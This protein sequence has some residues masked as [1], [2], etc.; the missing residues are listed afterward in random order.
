MSSTKK[1]A[2]DADTKVV[3]DK[4]YISKH[5]NQYLENVRKDEKSRLRK[6]GNN[7]LTGRYSMN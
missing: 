5:M 7:I 6:N 4:L 2:K 3:F 1:Y